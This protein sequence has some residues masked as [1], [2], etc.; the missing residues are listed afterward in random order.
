VNNTRSAMCEV[1]IDATESGFATAWPILNKSL[2]L[3]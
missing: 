1:A 3:G 2:G